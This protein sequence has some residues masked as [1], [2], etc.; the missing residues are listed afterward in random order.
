MLVLKR[1]V[2]EVVVIGDNIQVKVLDIEGET[3]KLGFV[4]PKDVEILRHE[5]YQSIR[6]ENLKASKH[7]ASQ[8]QIKNILDQLLSD[9][10][11]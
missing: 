3:I 5:V 6:E 4:A 8:E 9:N 1:K 7:Q 11:K 10:K 2:G